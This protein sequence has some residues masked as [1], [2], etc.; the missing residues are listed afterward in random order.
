MQRKCKVKSLYTVV[1]CWEFSGESSSCALKGTVFDCFYTQQTTVLSQW[2]IVNY[3]IILLLTCYIIKFYHNTN[4]ISVVHYPKPNLKIFFYQ[5]DK[6]TLLHTILLCSDLRLWSL[7]LIGFTP[8][9]G[10]ERYERQTKR[11]TNMRVEDKSRV[12]VLPRSWLRPLPPPPC[13]PHL[14]KP[15]RQDRGQSHT[16]EEVETGCILFLWTTTEV[17]WP[18]VHHIYQ[19]SS[20]WPVDFIITFNLGLVG[21]LNICRGTSFWSE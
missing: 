11:Y 14:Q 3:F 15:Q 9:D 5:R 13:A 16:E 2:T 7:F 20:V 1:R 12:K 18:L 8:G 21:L 4:L 17:Q 19:I 6:N 10:A